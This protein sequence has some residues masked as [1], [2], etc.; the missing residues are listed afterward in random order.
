MGDEG[1]EETIVTKSVMN[2]KKGG[3]PVETVEHDTQP[4]AEAA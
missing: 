1:D 2:F 3:S 4:Q